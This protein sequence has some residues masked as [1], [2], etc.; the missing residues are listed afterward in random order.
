VAVAA[1]IVNFRWRE[2]APHFLAAAA[3]HVFGCW[4][5]LVAEG[6][7]M[8]Q[9]KFLEKYTHHGKSLTSAAVQ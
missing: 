2:S 8:C 5:N 4:R 1:V 3:P 6:S 9:R 7:T